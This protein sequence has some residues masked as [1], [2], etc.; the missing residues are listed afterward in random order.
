MKILFAGTP[1]AASIVLKELAKQ[2][3][4]ALVVT[5]PDSEVGR[6][7]V[8]TPSDVAVVAQELSIPIL[9]TNQFGPEEFRVIQSLG[10]EK[11][12]VVAYGSL[13][14]AQALNLIPWWNLHF[15]VLPAWRG[16]A[17]LQHSLVNKNGQGLS[18]FQLETTL[19]TGPIIESLA[20]DLPENKPA[21]E[22]LK[23][24]ARVGAEMILRNLQQ[25]MEP[26]P[27]Q[28][29]PTF[30]PKILRSAARLDFR[31]P[32]LL[33]QRKIYAYNP[34]PVAWCRAGEK[35]LRVLRATAIGS[36]D[37]N[38][39]TEK[40]LL[41]GEIEISGSRVLVSCGLGSLLELLEVQPAGGKPM[42]ASDW[43][44]GYAGNNLE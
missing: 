25:P 15:S 35:D 22:L 23:E 2:H 8:L 24:L 17:P 1:E 13:I 37:W 16:A 34:E 44:R 26:K 39:L 30:A 28:G 20:L 41:P 4:I 18:L 43:Y 7:R 6:K 21:G 38:S 36:V 27:Q 14:P 11:A 12:V 29:S 5:R 19:D 33:L 42:L 31:E 32:A 9:K 3:E 40:K 10:V